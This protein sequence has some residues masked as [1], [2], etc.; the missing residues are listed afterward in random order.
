MP[1]LNGEGGG[2]VMADRPLKRLKYGYDIKAVNDRWGRVKMTFLTRYTG[3]CIDHEKWL[4]QTI[5]KHTTTPV[6]PEW[7]SNKAFT[8]MIVRESTPVSG[9]ENLTDRA[10][11]F[12]KNWS[13]D[14]VVQDAIRKG[15]IQC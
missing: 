2:S 15:V 12:D 10:I 4:Y 8:R 7:F 11:W 5:I 1:W 13:A 9:H 6:L 3:L 14:T